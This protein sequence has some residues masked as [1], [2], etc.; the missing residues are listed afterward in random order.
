MKNIKKFK[1]TYRTRK[2][3]KN[4]IKKKEIL[5][6]KRLNRSI[7]N[8]E[9]DL[10]TKI[11]REYRSINRNYR[12]DKSL[13]NIIEK[14]YKDNKDELINLLNEKCLKRDI[15]KLRSNASI[16]TCM[17]TYKTLYEI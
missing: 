10:L 1:T 2:K 7:S 12:D 11:K 16:K 17:E 5:Q 14:Y 13:K 6:E 4:R 9:V 15:K 8:K 3:V